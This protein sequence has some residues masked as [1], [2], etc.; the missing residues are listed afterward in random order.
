MGQNDR[1]ESAESAGETATARPMAAHQSARY[2]LCRPR[3]GLN[4]TLCQ[5]QRCVAYA[6][7]W[8]RILV[9]DARQSALHCQFS[10]V[11]EWTDATVSVIGW[12]DAALEEALNALPCLPEHLAGRVFEYQVDYRERVGHVERTSQRPVQFAG[13]SFSADTPDCSQPLLVHDDCGGGDH[14]QAVL[15]C[16]RLTPA[17]ATPIKAALDQLPAH[18][19]AVHIRNTDYRTDYQQVFARIATKRRSRPLWIC[20]DDLTVFETARRMIPGEVQHFAGRA[21]SQLALGT[22]HHPRSFQSEAEKRDAT[23][24]SLIDLF[25]LARAHTLYLGVLESHAVQGAHWHG[26]VMRRTEP[27]PALSGFSRLARFLHGEPERMAQLLDV[28]ESIEIAQAER[29]VVEI[30]LDPTLRRRL[31]LWFNTRLY[32]AN[33]RLQRSNVK[34]I[35]LWV[36]RMT[37]VVSVHRRR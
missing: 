36:I 11:F 9:I 6:S 18:F 15:A 22:R 33:Q 28:G 5:I 17:F 2:L 8:S 14:A 26:P 25:T 10:E 30:A 3:G 35:L 20:S 27:L 13:P 19:D 4:D 31:R 1:I 29:A 23:V 12:V 32:H 16:V 21:A 34:P 7:R 24:E 37:R